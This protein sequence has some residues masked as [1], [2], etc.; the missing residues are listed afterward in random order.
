MISKQ[1][2]VFCDGPGLPE[3]GEGS[4]C[5]MWVYVEALTPA[6]ARREVS[7]G[8]WAYRQGKDLCPDCASQV[9]SEGEP[10]VGKGVPGPPNG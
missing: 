1:L 3:H 9:D 7:T 5:G 10:D 6:G 4:T 2:T 8:G